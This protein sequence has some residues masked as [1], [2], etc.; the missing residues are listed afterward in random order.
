MDVHS[1][2]DL[3]LALDEIVKKLLAKDPDSPYRTA[4]H[5]AEALRKVIKDLTDLRIR[6]I[7]KDTEQLV[8]ERRFE[9]AL[10]LFNEAIRLAPSNAEVRKRR[11]SVRAQHEQTRRT[12]RIHE[13]LR[14]SD[15]SLLSGDFEESLSH[16]K[17]ARNLDPHSK[18]INEK[19][20]SVEKEKSRSESSTRAL[21]EFERAKALGD[22]VGALRIIA[23]A[24]QQDPTNP[25][26]QTLRAALATQ[27]EME[28]QLCRLL[29]LVD[30]ADR[31]MAVGNYEAAS[32][33]L[34]E[35][36]EIDPSNQKAA[37][38]RWE[39]ANARGMEQRRAFLDDIQQRIR[40]FFKSDA[41]DQASKLVNSALDSFPD[42]MLLH[43]LKAEVEAE[44]RRYDVRQVV[45]LVIAEVDELSAHSP[46]D[47]LSLLEK[48]LDNMPDEVR[49]IAH[50][51]ALSQQ[52]DP[53]KSEHSTGT[54]FRECQ[55][56]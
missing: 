50:E 34:N 11:K 10:K 18:A 4:E 56:R 16:L 43:R 47:A 33:L 24:L 49:L 2:R 21:E 48:A 52:I 42:E 7:L 40:D 38:L 5:F 17:D 6:E 14:R 12:E 26:F 36:A 35:A 27:M 44:E 13:C 54:R 22:F 51:R 3:P 1:S 37:K 23:K 28:V 45:D 55:S 25:K 15:E 31:D 32:N 41:Y 8:V 39:L 53:W 9:P 46:L 29:E 30:R 19:L 20:Q